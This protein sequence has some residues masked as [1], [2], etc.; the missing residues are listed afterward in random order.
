MTDCVRAALDTSC[1][2]SFAVQKGSSL[3]FSKRLVSRGRHSDRDLL[4]WLLASVHEGGLQLGHIHAWTVGLGPGSF[5]GIR[6]G[7][8]LVQGITRGSGARCRGL[9]SSLALAA[10]AAAACE[11]G[12]RIAVLHDARRDQLIRS[13][14]RRLDEGLRETAEP[15]IL[16]AASLP[17]LL[18]AVDVAITPH[19]EAV[20]QLL[21][22]CGPDAAAVRLEDVDARFLLT[23]SGWEWPDDP[24]ADAASCRPVYV[25][26]PVFV[27]AR[28]STG[29]RPD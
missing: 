24:S 25:R 20:S 4:P 13:M 14:Y 7:I 18:R 2:T 3:L 21:E 16:D 11:T 5:S 12:N 27:A 19:G 26:P 29:A 9:P 17:E 15:V 1:G 23:P 8:A 6:A 28:P 22:P 10:A